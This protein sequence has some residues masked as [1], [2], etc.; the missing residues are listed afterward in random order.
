MGGEIEKEGDLQTGITVL[1]PEQDL[2]ESINRALRLAIGEQSGKDVALR[3]E[4]EERQSAHRA[5]VT[6]LLKKNGVD[7]GNVR[8]PLRS[9]KFQVKREDLVRA[10][11]GWSERVGTKKPGVKGD[12]SFWKVGKPLPCSFRQTEQMTRARQGREDR[13]RRSGP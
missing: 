10:E 11:R 5:V 12:S 1:G 4:R 7:L 8:R 6:T 2:S 13:G 9:R 3:E